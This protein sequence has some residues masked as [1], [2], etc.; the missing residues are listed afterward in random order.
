MFEGT[1]Y[2]T[3]PIFAVPPGNG[4]TGPNDEVISI[5]DYG[6]F[7]FFLHPRVIGS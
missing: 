4:D 7:L 3:G 5:G 2:T 6:H 1:V